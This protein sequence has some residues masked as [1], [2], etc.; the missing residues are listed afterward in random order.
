M[1]LHDWIAKYPGVQALLQQPDDCL[2]YTVDESQSGRLMGLAAS[3]FLVHE[4]PTWVEE[5]LAWACWVA[6]VGRMVEQTCVGTVTVSTIY[7]GLD[8]DWNPAGSPLLFQTLAFGRG[9]PTGALA[10]Y[11]TWE[12]AVAGHAQ[13]IARIRAD[14]GPVE[15]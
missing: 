9:Q 6:P 14:E 12:A 5:T 11:A 7:L 3:E 15:S 13:V 8:Y 10:R 4:M 2:D 1:P